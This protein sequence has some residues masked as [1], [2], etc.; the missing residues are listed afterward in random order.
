MDVLPTFPLSYRPIDN[1]TATSMRPIL[2]P[3]TLL[4]IHY[5]VR[6]IDGRA[7][8][9]MS[10]LTIIICWKMQGPRAIPCLIAVRQT[11]ALGRVQSSHSPS[12]LPRNWPHFGW[13][14]A[15]LAAGGREGT[16]ETNV[17]K[18]RLER[19]RSKLTRDAGAAQHPWLQCKQGGLGS[20]LLHLT[21]WKIGRLSV[22]PNSFNSKRNER[23][24]KGH[25]VE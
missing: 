12:H 17:V 8:W 15:V 5:Q 10:D 7:A 20:P 11:A 23:R 13:D 18:R 4:T 16:G 22:L 24:V 6:N 25:E 3:K 1:R 2:I 14:L 9:R 19:G 21:E